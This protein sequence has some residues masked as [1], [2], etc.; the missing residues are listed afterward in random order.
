MGTIASGSSDQA[1]PAATVPSGAAAA[2]AAVVTASRT[3]SSLENRSGRP[4]ADNASPVKAV[5]L[6]VNAERH[7]AC[8]TGTL[9]TH[10]APNAVGTRIVA[11]TPTP[12]TM[13]SH[14]D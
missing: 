5:R 11:R 3:S 7:I 2:N 14:A 1:N 12:A 13:G 6:N 10:F 9:S 4:H 8:T